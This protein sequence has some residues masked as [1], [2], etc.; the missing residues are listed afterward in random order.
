MNII[1]DIKYTVSHEWIRIEGNTARI[2]ITDFAQNQMGTL[3]FV[4]LPEVD[5]EVGKGSPLAVVESVKA[6]SDVYAPL[7]GTITE[8]NEALADNPELINEEPYESWLVTLELS[9][10]SEVAELIDSAEYEKLCQQ[11]E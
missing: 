10:P 2:G 5:D 1:K 3:V 7:S 6:A 9:N 4:E 8:I 11:G